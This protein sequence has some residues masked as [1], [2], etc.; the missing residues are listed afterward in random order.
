MKPITFAQLSQLYFD[1]YSAVWARKQMQRLLLANPVLKAEF[2]GMNYRNRQV[3]FTPRQ[4]ELIFQNLG[5][6]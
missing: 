6:P 3:R 2:E 5:E 4:L 1:D